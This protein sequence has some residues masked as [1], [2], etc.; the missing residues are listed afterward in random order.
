MFCIVTVV[1]F[2]V[3]EDVVV[4]VPAYASGWSVPLDA[5]IHLDANT[6]K[7]VIIN[8]CFIIITRVVSLFSV[9][10][11]DKRR[12]TFFLQYFTEKLKHRAM[13]ISNHKLK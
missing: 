12:M 1:V 5:A 7:R 10:T 9:V 11:N 13:P 6:Q 3:V 8:N 2:V 4:V